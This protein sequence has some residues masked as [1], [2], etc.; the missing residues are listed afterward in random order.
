MLVN[1]KLKDVDVLKVGDPVTIFRKLV[2]TEYAIDIHA[3]KLRTK[4]DT[5]SATVEFY[6]PAN[7]P[8]FLV[9]F[10]RYLYEIPQT[11]L[12]TVRHRDGNTIELEGILSPDF[13]STGKIL[14]TPRDSNM[15]ERYKSIEEY[16]EP[17]FYSG[18]TPTGNSFINTELS[19][20]ILGG[21]IIRI[22]NSI[23]TKPS[24]INEVLVH[25]VQDSYAYIESGAF[26]TAV[27]SLGNGLCVW[28]DPKIL[29]RV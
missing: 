2:V 3:F 18:I 8:P 14:W 16:V 1:P 11:L 4:I 7:G 23:G 12:R 22:Y 9:K 15:R 10:P 5:R 19:P 25:Y 24:Y 27:L 21:K 26:Y 29:K 6:Y 13:S 17:T 20:T 28:V